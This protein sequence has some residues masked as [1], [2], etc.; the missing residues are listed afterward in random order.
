MSDSAPAS[1]AGAPEAVKKLSMKEGRR[2]DFQFLESKSVDDNIRDNEIEL[3]IERIRVHYGDGPAETAKKMMDKRD[4]PVAYWMGYLDG[5]TAGEKSYQLKKERKM[6]A[7]VERV[8]SLIDGLGKR[9][10]DLMKDA[11]Q[12]GETATRELSMV[13]SIIEASCSQLDLI[14]AKLACTDEPRQ[15]QSEDDHYATMIRSL[16]I[17][18][19]A[20]VDPKICV[21]ISRYITRGVVPVS[22]MNEIPNEQGGSEL[23]RALTIIIGYL[24]ANQYMD[25]GLYNQ[26]IA[27]D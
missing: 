20:D 6:V 16:S 27:K 11:A 3:Y 26:I 7:E 22:L 8:T 4:M 1:L 12:I 2:S 25:K 21:I 14:T 9:M 15:F 19:E 5:L 13:S 18:S 17:L 23:D 10:L 24:L